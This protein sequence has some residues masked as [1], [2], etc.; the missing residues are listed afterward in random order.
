MKPAT[1][2]CE[3]SLEASNSYLEQLQWDGI[4]GAGKLLDELNSARTQVVQD[5]K[6]Y[7]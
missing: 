3:T 1:Q 6:Y 7:M 5:V 4:E 2:T